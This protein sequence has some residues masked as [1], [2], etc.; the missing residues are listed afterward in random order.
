MNNINIMM[1]TNN[2]LRLAGYLIK[3]ISFD[4]FVFTVISDADDGGTHF[5]C[6]N[7]AFEWLI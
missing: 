2:T 3:F 6:K 7:L 1:Y 4:W 5:S